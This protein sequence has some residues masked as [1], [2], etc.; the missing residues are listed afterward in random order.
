MGIREKRAAVKT[1]MRELEK[2]NDQNKG[3]NETA[4]YLAANKK[5]DDAVRALPRGLRSNALNG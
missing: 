1:A 4:A 2:V 3:R 5:V